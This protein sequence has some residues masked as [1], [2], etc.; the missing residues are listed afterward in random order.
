MPV[1][2]DSVPRYAHP[3]DP[4]DVRTCGDCHLCKEAPRGE[5]CCIRSMLTA[6]SPDDVELE[7]VGAD[8]DACEHWR[9]SR[10][11]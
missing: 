5:L 10:W 4:S 9:E 3:T 7:E 8:W 2:P 11:V 6:D 1:N